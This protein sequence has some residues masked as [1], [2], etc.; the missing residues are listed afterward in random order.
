VR[1][2]AAVSS[3]HGYT[4]CPYKLTEH[5]GALQLFDWTEHEVEHFFVVL[6]NVHVG[7]ATQESPF[8]DIDFAQVL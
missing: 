3:V 7:L 2:D 1:H 4:H 6:S 5:S 8:T